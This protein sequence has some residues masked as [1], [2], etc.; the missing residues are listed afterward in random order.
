MAQHRTPLDTLPEDLGSLPSTY[1]VTQPSV[2]NSSS[3]GA[4]ASSGF[5]GL[6]Q[7]KHVYI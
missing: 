7:A 1:M 2:C 4:D 3:K 6:L 5:F